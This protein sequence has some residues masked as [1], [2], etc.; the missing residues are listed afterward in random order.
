MHTNARPGSIPPGYKFKNIFNLIINLFK[1]V[2][3]VGY[4]PPIGHVDF[5]PNGGGFQPGC[6]NSIA[7]PSCSHNRAVYLFTESITS[8]CSFIGFNCNSMSSFENG[9]CISCTN[10]KCSQFGN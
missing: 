7:D 2:L 8:S 3:R 5:Y 6:P 1:N 9:E 10:N 4:V